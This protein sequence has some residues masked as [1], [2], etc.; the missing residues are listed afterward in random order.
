MS[1][2]FYKRSARLTI[3]TLFD[4]A[5]L[6]DD[7][8]RIAFNFTRNTLSEPDQGTIQIYNLSKRNRDFLKNAFEELKNGRREIVGNTILP[9]ANRGQALKALEEPFK[10]KF[11]AGYA[12]KP[13]QIFQ[14]NIVNLISKR[15]GSNDWVT[16]IKVGD[17]LIAYREGY[18]SEGFAPGV[19]YE[20]FR[21]VLELT[22]GLK[23]SADAET[24]IKQVAPNAVVTKDVN[25]GI[26]VV[27]RAS[28]ALDELAEMY[29]LQ[30]WHRDGQIYY[31]PQGAVTRD[32]SIVVQ[33]GIDVVGAIEVMG[34]DDVKATVL[35]NPRLYP[36]RGMF[37]VRKPV[38]FDVTNNKVNP[39]T[40]LRGEHVG[41]TNGLRCEV[42]TYIGDT[43]GQP[44]YTQFEARAA[45]Q[46]VV[47]PSLEFTEAQLDEAFFQEFI[48]G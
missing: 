42:A 11:F 37:A 7:G 39:I 3:G 12:K 32:F 44:W 35:L 33:E 25:G 19:T 14:G 45:T 41:S 48:D 6:D 13:E 18:I 46:A 22:Q 8:L 27:G 34:F 38:P 36:G 20:N 31:V 47:A 1:T 23:P 21:K 24:V 16:E 9:D 2:R 40:G 15:S 10:I 4:I 5:N 29:G 17:G 26:A 43:H 28:D 30:W